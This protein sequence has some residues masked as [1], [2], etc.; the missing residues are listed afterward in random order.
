MHGVGEAGVAQ[1]RADQL[2]AQDFGAVR[3]HRQR[4][5]LTRLG[6]GAVRRI[7][8]VEVVVRNRWQARFPNGRADA[9]CHHSTIARRE[10]QTIG[11]NA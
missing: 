5:L 6:D 3:T 4:A 9:G 2:V 7:R 10:A 11:A 8:V 1:D